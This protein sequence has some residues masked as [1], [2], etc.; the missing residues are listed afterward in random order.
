MALGVGTQG[1]TRCEKRKLWP[2]H[3]MMADVAVLTPQ[4]LGL[5]GAGGA[6]GAD[7]GF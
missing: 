1:L 3:K 4:D 7:G 2:K 6:G 5:V